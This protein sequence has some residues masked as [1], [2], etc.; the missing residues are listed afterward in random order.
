MRASHR[1]AS[2]KQKPLA[3]SLSKVLAGTPKTRPS[4]KGEKSSVSSR[5]IDI[6]SEQLCEDVISYLA[7]TLEQ[8][9]G[10]TIIDFE[11]GAC[12]FSS[13]LHRHLKP[14]KHILVEPDQKYFEPFVKPLLKRKG[15]RYVHSTLTSA[16][17]PALRWDHGT[18]I[19]LDPQLLPE[20]KPLPDGDERLMKFDPSLLIIGNLARR[21][22]QRRVFVN[23]R[24]FELQRLVLFA[25][26]KDL[27][28]KSGFFE[29]GLV[30]MLWWLPDLAKPSAMSANLPNNRSS[31]NVGLDTAFTTSEVSGVKPMSSLLDTHYNKQARRLEELDVLM[32]QQT[33][34]RAKSTT[35][36]PER[37]VKRR[38]PK[39][40]RFTKEMKKRAAELLSPLD[41]LAETSE[42]LSTK[43]DTV[44]ARLTEISKWAGTFRVAKTRDEDVIRSALQTL[45]FPQCNSLDAIHHNMNTKSEDEFANARMIATVDLGLRIIHLEASVKEVE[46]R[47]VTKEEEVKKLQTRILAINK[48]FRKLIQKGGERLMNDVSRL[49]EDQ[50]ACFSP[51]T[52]LSW[53]NRSY[54]P[55]QASQTDFYPETEVALLDMMPKSVDLSVPDL[56]DSVEST[57]VFAQLITSL[58][59][60]K[61]QPLPMALERIAVNAGKDLVP[62]VPAITDARKGGRLDP[63]NVRARMLTTEMLEGL[64]KAWFE[65]PFRPQSWQLS[66]AT[67]EA[68]TVEQA[69][70]IDGE[71][72]SGEEG[73]EER[74]A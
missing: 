72:E 70:E 66:L 16:T 69:R 61:K 49:L 18:R 35:S 71:G 34:L 9:K 27:L 21:G 17:H 56:A 40:D 24:T 33:A 62:Q 14:K 12:L 13:H 68:E 43:I 60:N 53:D 64:V 36:T 22:N 5:R 3:K 58:L 39:A 59:L 30:R 8:H 55:L 23:D 41:S 20:R 65:W 47:G 74:E 32:A 73:D 67:G 57:K 44:S 38:L 42:D 28:S 50:M 11:P 15:S 25:M 52:L 46:D 19:Q 10:C 45:Q 7:P 4:L 29:A 31:F 63:R 48:Q 1:L 51:T 2:V 6:V 26:A 54:E 37:S